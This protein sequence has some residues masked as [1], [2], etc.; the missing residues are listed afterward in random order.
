MSTTTSQDAYRALLRDFISPALRRV[1][2]K[3]SGGTY[4]LPDDDQW[5]LVGFQRSVWGDRHETRF[6]ANLTVASKDGWARRRREEPTW[7]KRPAANTR[8]GSSIWQS[9]IGLILPARV[10]TWW[11]I[12]PDSN[13]ASLAS[14]VLAA[15][16]DHGLP[17][18][19]EQ[20]SKT[21][22]PSVTLAD[23]D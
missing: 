21:A 17:A 6:T 1:G 4:V 16:R 9:R 8:Y 11:T 22:Y 23:T 18:L 7:P 13:L 3:G 15:L 19:Q 5:V 20:L 14:D 10:D 2:F 12:R